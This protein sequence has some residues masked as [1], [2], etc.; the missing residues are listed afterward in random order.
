MP[1]KKREELIAQDRILIPLLGK[2]KKM[3]NAKVIVDAVGQNSQVM[4]TVHKSDRMKV[5]SVPRYDS[6]D[7]T[8]L[9]TLKETEYE[10][11]R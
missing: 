7:G 8:L 11:W 2:D 6:G 5:G 9:L 3:F 1:S 10:L 4:I